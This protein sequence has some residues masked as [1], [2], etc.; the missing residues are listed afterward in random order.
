MARPPDFTQTSL[1]L[2]LLAWCKLQLLTPACTICPMSK[3]PSQKWLIHLQAMLN[4]PCHPLH[5]I[6]SQL[7][8][9]AWMVTLYLSLSCCSQSTNYQVTKL[10]HE[11]CNK[12][13]MT[14][15]GI[16]ILIFVKCSSSYRIV[17]CRPALSAALIVFLHSSLSVNWISDIFHS[18]IAWPEIML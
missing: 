8:P 13:R 7:V 15:Y 10:T 17:L 12:L 5:R 6:V 14:W 1:A 4:V 18:V 11:S 3:H 2:L 16:I 9:V